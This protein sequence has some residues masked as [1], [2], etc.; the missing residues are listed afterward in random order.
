MLGNP[1]IKYIFSFRPSSLESA[2]ALDFQSST[3]LNLLE[4]RNE[5]GSRKRP[6]CIL[7]VLYKKRNALFESTLKILKENQEPTV[8]N[9]LVFYS[10]ETNR[11]NCCTKKNTRCTWFF[12]NWI[13][14]SPC[15]CFYCFMSNQKSLKLTKITNQPS[16]TVLTYYMYLGWRLLLEGVHYI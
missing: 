13:N 14:D 10:H 4:D 9:S 12:K 1:P 3:S 6:V 11:G 5:M 2:R 7:Y 16:S 15:T 8:I